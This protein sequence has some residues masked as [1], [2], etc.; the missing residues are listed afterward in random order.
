MTYSN[1]TTQDVIELINNYGIHNVTYS[2]VIEIVNGGIEIK[3]DDDL[4]LN[5]ES[6]CACVHLDYLDNC[7]NEDGIESILSYVNAMLHRSKTH[8]LNILYK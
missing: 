3:E 8:D 6:L 5:Q 4:K 1:L 7:I 2:T